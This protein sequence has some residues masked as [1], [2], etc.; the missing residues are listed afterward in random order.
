MKS[1]TTKQQDKV[2]S[3]VFRRLKA[4]GFKAESGFESDHLWYRISSLKLCVTAKLDSQNQFCWYWQTCLAE[5]VPLFS[6]S[7]VSTLYAEFGNLEMVLKITLDKLFDD[8][9]SC[10]QKYEATRIDALKSA[11]TEV[12]DEH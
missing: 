4:V 10:G 2:Y 1:L 12:L 8:G 3:S 6:N 9:V 5:E 11:I 7:G